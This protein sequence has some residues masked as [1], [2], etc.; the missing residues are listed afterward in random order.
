MGRIW[1]KERGLE[2]RYLLIW[3]LL[4]VAAAAFVLWDRHLAGGVRAWLCEQLRMTEAEARLFVAFVAGVHDVGKAQPCFQDGEPGPQAAGFIRH[5]LA[6]YLALPSLLADLARCDPLVESVPHRIG[7][8]VGAHHG[9]FQDVNRRLV[10]NP[11]I[12]ARLGGAG[13]QAERASLVASLRQVLGAPV[14]PAVFPRPVA[15]VVTGLVIVADWLASDVEWI[16][17]SQWD[18]PTDPGK[19][20]AATVSSLRDRVT[21]LGLVLPALSPAVSTQMLIGQA[22]NPLQRSLEEEFRPAGPGLLV[23]T[24]ST[25]YG[26]TE[27]A[28][29]GA[30]A[31]GEASGRPGLVLCLPTQ[32]TTNAMWLR[33]VGFEKRMSLE[34]GPVTMMHAMSGFYQP[35]REYCADDVALGWL[36]GA[37]RPLLGG[38]SVVT[39]DQVLLAALATRFNMVRLWALTGK[40]LIVDEVH[41]YEP[42][43]LG[44]LARVLSW[45]GHLR[46]PV[47]LMSATLP[48][49]IACDLTTAYL[50][51]AAPGHPHRVEAPA[52]PGWRFTPID[53]PAQE[54]SAIAVAG[55]R[56]HGRR[57]ARLE[58]VRYRPGARR[59]TILRELEQ[60]SAGGGCVAVIC[61]TVPSAQATFQ[62]LRANLPDEVPVRLLHARF[63]YQQRVSLEATLLAELGK[64]ATRDN[65]RR[66]ARMVLVSTDIVEQSLDVDFDLIITDLAPIARLIQRLGRCWRHLRTGRPGWLA[67]PRLAVLDPELDRM[68]EPWCGIH[69]EYELLATRRVL[70][71][72][73]ADL[74]VPDDVDE[75]VQRV[76]DLGLPPID[77]AAADAWRD[78]RATT[79]VHRALAG[80]AATPPPHLVNDLARLTR[81]GVE[82][83]DV[84]TRLGIDAVRLIP[85]YQDDDGGL[86]LDV[87]HTTRFPRPHLTPERI[88]QLVDASVPCP[89]AWTGG[90]EQTPDRWKHPLLRTARILPAPRHR[91]LRLHPDLGLVKGPIHDDL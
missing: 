64:D 59:A 20:W 9:R 63:P 88:V 57:R 19:R 25:G 40:V 5:E 66:P 48:R 60:V 29:I 85:Q 39:V 55:M 82:E 81:H 41:A 33:G 77:G 53:G 76:H 23:I 58:H 32:A 89:A 62:H 35:Y 61:A 14:L 79:S 34:P 67:G 7:E 17:R 22:P 91:D 83:A 69:P 4:D 24:A 13:W 71:E 74:V 56:R 49:H 30:R 28:V 38:L 51:G 6:G 45:C 78:R 21:G 42:Y 80:I 37:H 12:D 65:G 11:A 44:L 86:W 84:T 68:P 47:V 75:L 73:G 3:H 90:L 2:G 46:V 1:G 72:R 26:K 43:M 16:A 87:E 52:Y 50:D 8:V 36:N 54:P 27:A 18:A 31:L 10:R 15:A 70:A